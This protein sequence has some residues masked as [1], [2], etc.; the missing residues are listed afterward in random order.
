MKK[1]SLAYKCEECGGGKFIRK[2]K[3]YDNYGSYKELNN[4]C[5]SSKPEFCTHISGYTLK[6]D[7]IISVI[8]SF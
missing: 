5:F 2:S 1:D 3:F 4:Y 8:H 6:Q 7:R